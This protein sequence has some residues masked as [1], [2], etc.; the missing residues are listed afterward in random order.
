MMKA[1]TAKRFDMVA[2]WSVD[3]LAFL[4]ASPLDS[5][6]NPGQYW[7]AEPSLLSS[8]VISGAPRGN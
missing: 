5:V 2:A 7:G 8:S 6:L 4:R 3:R 1:V